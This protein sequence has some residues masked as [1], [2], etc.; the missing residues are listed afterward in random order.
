MGHIFV[1]LVKFC[2]W[3]VEIDP[4]S[5]EGQS[6]PHEAM[7]KV[8]DYLFKDELKHYSEEMA[9][10]LEDDLEIIEHARKAGM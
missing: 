5:P 8:I 3:Y 7:G 4:N 1:D 2:D 6:M 10:D 9:G